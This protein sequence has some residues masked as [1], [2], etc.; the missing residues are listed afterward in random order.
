MSAKIAVAHAHGRRNNG[1]P[2]FIRLS[3]VMAKSESVGHKKSRRKPP[4]AA[5]LVIAVRLAPAELPAID[6]WI[7]AQPSPKPTRAEAI[8]RLAQ[9]ALA[10]LRPV[11]RRSNKSTTR[12]S[13]MAGQAIDHLGEHAATDEVRAHRKRRLLKGPSEFRAMREDLPTKPKA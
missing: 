12:A 3:V 7:K 10:R 4:G 9:I 5:A 13:D 1:Y 6:A 11:G 2:G 8:R